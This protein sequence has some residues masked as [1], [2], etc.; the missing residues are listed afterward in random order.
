MVGGK[1]MS[2]RGQKVVRILGRIKGGVGLLIL[3]YVNRTVEIVR[4]VDKG[5]RD[6]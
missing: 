5:V 6:C 3:Q 4:L 1:S 2:Y